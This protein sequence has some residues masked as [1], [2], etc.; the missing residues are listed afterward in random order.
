MRTRLTRF[1][2][3]PK[4]N[5]GRDGTLWYFQAW[6]DVFK[7]RHDCRLINELARV[8]GELANLV[9]KV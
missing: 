9:D 7:K 2:T 4:F 8:V 3:K 6:V 1:G 5:G